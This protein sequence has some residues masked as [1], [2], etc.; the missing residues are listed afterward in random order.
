[1]PSGNDIISGM[2]NT[3]ALLW[4]ADCIFCVKTS[5]AGRGRTAEDRGRKDK[6]YMKWGFQGL[7]DGLSALRRGGPDRRMKDVFPFDASVLARSVRVGGCRCFECAVTPEE[8]PRG[9]ETLE[10]RFG[11]WCELAGELLYC[12]HLQVGRGYFGLTRRPVLFA[13]GKGGRGWMPVAVYYPDAGRMV[14]FICDG[15]QRL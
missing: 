12:G 4:R 13:A 7:A 15:R 2:K 8:F 9:K 3:A 14:Y 10:A 5:G 11:A 1:M 6:R